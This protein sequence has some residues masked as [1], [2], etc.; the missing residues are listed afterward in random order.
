MQ[1]HAKFKVHSPSISQRIFLFLYKPHCL[2]KIKC[3]WVFA[4]LKVIW[5]KLE[6]FPI[7]IINTIMKKHQ[8]LS[9]DKHAIYIMINT[10]AAVSPQNLFMRKEQQLF[11]TKHRL[12]NCSGKNGWPSINNLRAAR[13]VCVC[14]CVSFQCGSVDNSD[15]WGWGKVGALQRTGGCLCV[16]VLEYQQQQGVW[17]GSQRELIGGIVCVWNAEPLAEQWLAMCS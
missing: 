9:N 7:K 5:I 6:I 1:N 16:C 13:P 17:K 12:T 3:K 8:V 4:I 10:V 11:K 2:Y 14:V 15:G